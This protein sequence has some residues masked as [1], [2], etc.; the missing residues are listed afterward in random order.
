MLRTCRILKCNSG[1]LLYN[2]RKS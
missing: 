1:Y 2:E